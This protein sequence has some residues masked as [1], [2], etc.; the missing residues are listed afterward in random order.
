MKKNI[1]IYTDG[2][3]SNGTNGKRISSY[4]AIILTGDLIDTVYG[5]FH[6][7]TI[8]RMEL[9]AVIK[10][11]EQLRDPSNITVYSDSQYVVRGIN[12]WL[13]NWKNNNFK[14]R[15]NV[16]LWSRYID[17]VEI[18]KIK[19]VWVKAHN[20]DLYNEQADKICTDIVKGKIKVKFKTDYFYLWFV[21][22][23]EE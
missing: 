12:E 13:G 20:N 7:S 14:E 15:K 4:A 3:A 11:V 10:G 9:I 6:Q 8:G 17:A 19:A 2:S 23:K 1:T 22:K 16:D 21:N 5:G 18:H